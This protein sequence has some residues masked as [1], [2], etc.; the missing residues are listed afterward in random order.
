[1]KKKITRSA[2]SQQHHQ[3][4]LTIVPAIN[5]HTATALQEGPYVG[6][7]G[8]GPSELVPFQVRVVGGVDEVV[9]KG[10]GH[11]LGK[12]RGSIGQ[13]VKGDLI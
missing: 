2:N 12:G 1:M 4:N 9:R 8:R 5:L 3:D 10:L 11:I 13:K 6:V 7:R